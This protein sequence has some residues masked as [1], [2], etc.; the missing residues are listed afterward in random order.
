M[1]FARLLVT[2]LL[3]SRVPLTVT[4]S[5]DKKQLHVSVDSSRAHLAADAPGA[6]PEV[7]PAIPEAP[8][9]LSDTLMSPLPVAQPS[10]PP[11]IPLSAP[12]RRPRRTSNHKH[13]QDGSNKAND[14]GDDDGDDMHVDN[15]KYKVYIY[16][17]DDELA[18]DEQSTSSDTETADDDEVVARTTDSSGKLVFL[19]DID[20]HLRKTARNVALN[21]R[22][23]SPSAG[24]AGPG[25]SLSHRK[26]AVPRPILP[27]KDGELAGMQLVLYNEPSSLSVSRDSDSVRQAILDARAR[28]RERQQQQQDDKG[29][30][31]AAEQLLTQPLAQPLAQQLAQQLETDASMASTPASTPRP[32]EADND[33]D[34]MDID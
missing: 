22:A 4:E 11:T 32:A 21:G 28:I 15:T 10:P 20:K 34:A 23:S 31:R 8:V 5:S 14:G 3:L 7:A 30:Q 27:N 24:S 1:C 9:I 13:D 12:A 19:P 29:E 33:S 18:D 2:G 16:N 6:A 17:I 26:I 25:P